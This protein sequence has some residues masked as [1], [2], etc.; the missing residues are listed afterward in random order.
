MINESQKSTLQVLVNE[1]TE[2]LNQLASGNVSV[3]EDIWSD[4]DILS[5]YANDIIDGDDSCL[6]DFEMTIEEFIT[7]LQRAN[8][9]FTAAAVSVIY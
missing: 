8:D 1:S 9:S 3:H 5:D 6:E 2:L 4:V 7:D